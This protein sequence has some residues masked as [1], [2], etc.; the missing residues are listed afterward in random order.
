AHQDRAPIDLPLAVAVVWIAGALCL[1]LRFVA[2]TFVVWRRAL[3]AAPVTDAQ[4]VMLARD[5]ARE[6][7]IRRPITLLM[8]R[9][10]T[11]PVTWGVV[12]PVVLLP[13]DAGNWSPA[14][15]RIVLL[16]ELAHVARFDA[17]MHLVGQFVLAANWFNPLVWIA[18][19]RMRAE[20]ER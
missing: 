13:D 15:R 14:R 2:G 20:R 18:M 7:R 16:H 9:R 17:A 4:W 11:V 1:I 6:L 19:A 3:V 10:P 5:V 12:Y 8:T